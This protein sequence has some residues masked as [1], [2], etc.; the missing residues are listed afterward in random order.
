[1]IHSLVL[2][3]FSESLNIESELQN[4]ARGASPV[5]ANFKVTDQEIKCVQ[6]DFQS[7]IQEIPCEVSG[8]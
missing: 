8:W 1:M 3:F 2:D 7:V 6:R 4:R 5:G